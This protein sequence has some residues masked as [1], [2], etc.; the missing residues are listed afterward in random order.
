M[1]ILEIGEQEFQIGEVVVPI[2]TLVAEYQ[3]SFS[4]DQRR[5]VRDG[6]YVQFKKP[7]VPEEIAENMWVKE[8]LDDQ[9]IVELPD[10]LYSYAY[11]LSDEGEIEFGEPVKVEVGYEPVGKAVSFAVKMLRQQDGGVVVGGPMCLF[12]DGG[13]KDLQGDYF[14]P[15]TETWHEMYKSVPA[16]FHHGLDDAV[17]LSVIGHRIKAEVRDDGLWVEDWLDTSSKYWA[18]VKPLLEAEA[19]Y[20]SPGSAP[21]L[22]KTAADGRLLSYPVIEDTLTPIPAQHRLRPIE[23][24]KAAYKAA[25]IDLPGGLEPEPDADAGGDGAGAP[26]PGADVAKVKVKAELLLIQIAEEDK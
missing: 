2:G 18:L 16:L 3:K 1:E 11:T 6:W 12:G 23:Q 24:I 10:G 14:T 26:C 5:L 8:V 21:H 22:V 7:S 20:Y 15:E 17:G 19:L 4:L 9:V 25:G 13:R